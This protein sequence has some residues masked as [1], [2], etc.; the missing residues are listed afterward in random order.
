[1]LRQDAEARGI[2]VSAAIRDALRAYYQVADIGDRAWREAY[3]ACYRELQERF[4]S[5]LA[6]LPEFP[7]PG[8]NG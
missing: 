6:T 2:T 1:M 7:P 8:F 5:A 4:Q 3:L